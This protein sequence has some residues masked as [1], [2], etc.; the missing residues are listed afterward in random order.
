MRADAGGSDV[1]ARHDRNG[2]EDMSTRADRREVEG[3]GAEP[4]ERTLD[5][6]ETRSKL[7]LEAAGL[8]TFRVDLVTDIVHYS[9][10]LAAMLGFPHVVST[11]MQAAIMRVH[12]DDLARV[13]ALYESALDPVGDGRLRMELRY[14]RPG[15]E[16]RWMTWN[17]RVEFRDGAGGRKPFRILGACA[18]VTERM[19]AVARLSE[20]EARFRALV[21]LSTD[22]YWEQD[23]NFRF[24]SFSDA[25]EELAGSPAQSHVGKTRWELPTVGV[26]DAEWAAHQALLERHEPFRN[27]EYQRINAKGETIWM[28]VNGDPIFD[29]NG[30]FKGYRGT[31]HNITERKLTEA[32]LRESEARF[33]LLAD[34]A[35]V[36]IWVSGGDGAEFFNKPYLNFVGAQSE[37]ELKG[38][39]WA[40]SLHPDDREAYLE[41]FRAC[42]ARLDQFEAQFR[43]RRADGRYRWMKSIGLPRFA[44]DGRC[45]GYVGSTLDITDIKA[46][47]E[48]IAHLAREL[49]HRVKNI[50]N[51]FVVIVDRTGDSPLSTDEFVTALKDRIESMSRAHSLLSR[52]NWSG[53]QLGELIADQLEAYATGHNVKVS[54]EPLTLTPDA[55]QAISMVV[56]EL[57]TNAAKYG[58]L[59]VGS[60]QVAVTWRKLP[61][62]AAAAELLRIEWEELSGP[63]VGEPER[64]GFGT[65]VI[66]ELLA[67]EFGG[68]VDLDLRPEGARC[69][70][71]LPLARI[72]G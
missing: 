2:A 21:E 16:V 65:R 22:W 53:V 15:G 45:L 5:E 23:E 35:P 12:R 27:L 25:V 30:R 28:S 56:N 38:L 6:S 54:G 69:V 62:A 10:E 19:E 39:G 46:N 11:P 24:L 49:D 3:S 26:S 8:G 18:D 42:E 32:R 47:E 66:R 31:G 7:A 51:R 59:S 43:F 1:I 4:V 70:I 20:S 34:S 72:A 64:S 60:G 44:A 9:P 36:L 29:A 58:A 63:L 50:L 40:Q 13:K 48:R 71:S 14:V 68:Q 41:T 33:R 61:A 52:T 67:H 57:A 37:N 55:A 17:G